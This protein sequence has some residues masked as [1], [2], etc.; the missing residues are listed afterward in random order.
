[1]GSR[2]WNTKSTPT[3]NQN[4]PA[5]SIYDREMRQIEK[6]GYEL[7]QK[8]AHKELTTKNIN[9]MTLE[10][11]NRF[12]ALGFKVELIVDEETG[13]YTFSI[14]GRT[15]KHDFDIEEKI[16]EVKRAKERNEHIS[17]L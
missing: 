17:E 5:A 1:M 11:Q 8:F 9:D 12:A 16:W 4:T 6:L 3:A 2:D 15:E 14:I 13:Y 7:N 10:T